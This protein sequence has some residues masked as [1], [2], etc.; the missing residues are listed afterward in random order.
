MI[1]KYT[2]NTPYPVGPVHFYLKNYG[3]YDVLFD[4]GPYTDEAK[5]YLQKT[6]DLSRLKYTLVTHCHADH[7][8][9]ID[10]IHNNSDSKIILAKSDY[11]RFARFDDRKRCFLKMVKEYGFNEAELSAIEHVLIRFKDEVPMPN[12]VFI[13]EE[14]KDIL[15]ELQIS[16]IPCPGHSQ[17]DIVYLV[18]NY[19]ITGD[20]VLRDIFQTPLLDIDI[21]NFM[22]R[23]QN[24]REFCNTIE[25]LKNIETMTFLPG[26]REYIDS[27][28]ERIIFYISKLLERASL[29]KDDLRNKGIS[30][31]LRKLVDDLKLNPLKAYLKLSEVVFINDFLSEPEIMLSVLDRVNLLDT[32]KDNLAKLFKGS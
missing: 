26:H 10:F 9:L 3:K 15:E 12:E 29:I 23:F 32:L 22:D 1:K 14:S 18:D 31:V 5:E 16:Y 20:V 21:S 25:K 27:V 7:Y 11:L 6:I 28:D 30:F 2:V 24:Y 13:L 19:A 4:T 17:S 8:G